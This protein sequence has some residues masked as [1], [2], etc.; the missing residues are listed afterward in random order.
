MR[1]RG[2]EEVTPPSRVI[3][4]ALTK[5]PALL[6]RNKAVPAMSSGVPILVRGMV[7]TK[8]VNVFL[9]LHAVI[10]LKN[11]PHAMVL[12]VMPSHPSLPPIARER[13]WRP[14]LLAL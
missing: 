13:W 10:L 4:A 14:A 2:K 1:E 6:D 9:R 7:E 5:A 3:V 8:L 11:G 12:L